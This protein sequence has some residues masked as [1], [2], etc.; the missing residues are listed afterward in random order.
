ML[1]PQ[2]TPEFHTQRSVLVLFE[3]LLASLLKPEHIYLLDISME[4]T[5]FTSVRSPI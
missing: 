3:S 1:S 2:P 4:A 5:G